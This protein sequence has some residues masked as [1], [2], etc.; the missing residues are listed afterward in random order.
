MSAVDRH[1]RAR[2][3]WLLAHEA[4]WH[5]S[6]RRM[7][8]ELKRRAA[9]KDRAG[10]GAIESSHHEG[11]IKPIHARFIA[12]GEDSKERMAR[13]CFLVLIALP[14]L[15]VGL[16]PALALSTVAYGATTEARLKKGAVPTRAPWLIAA[17][18]AA[19]VGALIALLFRSLITVATVTFYPSL[20]VEVHWTS[21]WLVYGWTQ[22]VLGLVLTAWQI[23]RHGWPGVTIKR[24][25]KL[26]VVPEASEAPMPSD[27][28]DSTGAAERAAGSPALP[29][30]PE[31]VEWEDEDDFDDENI[32]VVMDDGR[33]HDRPRT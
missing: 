10:A 5:L 25:P 31:P 29:V 6:D 1:E 18:V 21:V 3:D 32:V 11:R 16:G 20:T 28:S 26:L 9:Q 33:E 22:L 2:A 13:G 12:G 17:A 7:A 15:A 24:A 4:G 27:T 19:A 30:I 23:R 8:T 14:T